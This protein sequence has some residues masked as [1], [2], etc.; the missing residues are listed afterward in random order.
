MREV[1]I[2]A[3]GGRPKEGGGYNQQ[4]ELNGEGVTNTLT[5]VQKDNYVIEKTSIKSVA[6]DEFPVIGRSIG[7][8]PDNPGDRRPGIEL[9]QRLEINTQRVANTLT[10][11]QKDNY[12]VEKNQVEQ[13]AGVDVH[14]FS[15]KLEFQGYKQSEVSPC[16]LA[17]DYKAPKT[18]LS[19]TPKGGDSEISYQFRIRKLTPKECWRLMGFTDEDFHK[20]EAVCSNS[21]LYQQA[22]NSIAVPC[23]EGIFENLLGDYKMQQTA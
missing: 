3:V 6:D 2:G 13:L 18:I 8:N 21:K 5:S 17:T 16:L 11:V 14:P 1:G 23:L 7:R 10:T 20:A 12:V 22:G 19:E 15:K 9:E 4:L